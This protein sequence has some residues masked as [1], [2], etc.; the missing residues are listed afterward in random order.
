M[1]TIYVQYAWYSTSR[2]SD[3]RGG[4]TLFDEAGLEC[5]NK[6]GRLTNAVSSLQVGNCIFRR[7]RRRRGDDNLIFLFDS[8]RYDW[9][10]RRPTSC[11]KQAMHGRKEEKEIWRTNQLQLHTYQCRQSNKTLQ[12]LITIRHS[13]C[14]I[15][16]FHNVWGLETDLSGILQKKTQKNGF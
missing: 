3:I 11:P 12:K 14:E 8:W 16:L 6:S 5:I 4:G 10:R 13:N 2:I 15:G 1:H 9:N 7:R